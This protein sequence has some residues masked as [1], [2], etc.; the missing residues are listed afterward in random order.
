MTA[1]Q[2]LRQRTQRMY[3]E[4]VHMRDNIP[5]IDRHLLEKNE[6]YFLTSSVDTLEI[7]EKKV[8][9]ILKH[10]DSEPLGQ[11]TIAAAINTMRR[12]YIVVDDD[13]NLDDTMER[14]ACFCSNSDPVWHK[15]L[16]LSYG[17]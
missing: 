16:K 11:P 4:N 12:D 7:W 8:K 5:A 9:E 13:G 15:R 10:I 1:E 6:S 17:F 14:K 2:I 3:D